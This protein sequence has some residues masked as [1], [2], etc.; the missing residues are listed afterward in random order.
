MWFSTRHSNVIGDLYH[1][2]T[3]IDKITSRSG[4][5]HFERFQTCDNSSVDGA[6]SGVNNQLDS[7]WDIFDKVVKRF[8]SDILPHFSH[9]PAKTLST[10]CF[11]RNDQIFL[12]K[13]A[14]CLNMV[15]LTF[16]VPV[17]LIVSAFFLP[18]LTGVAGT[19][20]ERGRLGFLGA[21]GALLL[22]AF[23]IANPSDICEKV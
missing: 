18:R 5:T 1:A 3:V 10:S 23:A 4:F 19:G 9:S 13:V 2:E 14:S 20:I 15:H 12:K 8:Y 21:R 17:S 11:Q 7:F 6:S 16:Q 22:T